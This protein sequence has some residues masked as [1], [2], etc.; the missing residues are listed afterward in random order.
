M[1]DLFVASG[2]FAVM[3]E[4]FRDRIFRESFPKIFDNVNQEH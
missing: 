2:G 1:S 4:E 3:H